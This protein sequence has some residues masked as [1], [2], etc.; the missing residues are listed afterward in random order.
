MNMKSTLDR[1]SIRPGVSL[2]TV[3][4]HLNYKPWYALAE[5]LDNSVQSYLTNRAALRRL[6]GKRFVLSIDVDIDV[7]RGVIVV[8]DNAA[9]IGRDAYARAFRPAEM[10]AD[11][12]GLSEF[13]MGMKSAAAWL[14]PHWTV[15]TSALGEAVE[16]TVSFDIASIVADT[17]EELEVRTRRADRDAHF[18]E[19]VLKNIRK[20]PKNRTLAKIR[21]HLASLYRRFLAKGEIMITLNGEP[22]AFEQPE[23]LTAPHWRDPSG[24]ARRW[25]VPIDIR[26][27]GGRRVEGW[28]ALRARGS[29]TRAGFALLRRDRV[30]EGS[31]D[32]TYRPREL[33]GASNSFTYQRL[34]GELSLV[35]FAVSHTKDGIRWDEA[36]DDLIFRLKELLSREDMPLLDQAQNWRAGE[37]AAPNDEAAP[38]GEKHRAKHALPGRAAVRIASIKKAEIRGREC[39]KVQMH[40]GGQTWDVQLSLDPDGDEDDWLLVHSLDDEID[41]LRRLQVTL[42]MSHPFS[43]KFV[44]EGEKVNEGV[45]RL[46]IGLAIAEAIAQED[47]VRSAGRVRGSI[48]ELLLLGLADA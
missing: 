29:T 33:F 48:N 14:A 46:V 47:G 35:G 42:S 37:V 20:A 38:G 4:P 19:I 16:R 31:A 34:F 43:K 10:P 30:I 9:G 44:A 1:V 11:A 7:E 39:R 26:L 15:R 2:L 25:K 5:F 41:G 36:E 18:T 17:V 13:G 8:R 12:S 24:E 32:E 22:L 3:L 40:L 45:A 6:E 23:V 28:A 21:D 27:D